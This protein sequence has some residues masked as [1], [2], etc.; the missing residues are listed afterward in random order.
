MRVSSSLMKFAACGF[1]VDLSDLVVRF[2]VD[3]SRWTGRVR[4][5][6]GSATI[7]AGWRGA[8]GAA[9]GLLVGVEGEDERAC[10]DVDAV[11]AELSEEIARRLGDPCSR[12]E[13]TSID[14][15]AAWYEDGAEKVR[16][17]A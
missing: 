10:E 9:D 1:V 4:L 17:T 3:A 15:I 11:A 12:E 6:I 16:R 7:T 2:G 8:E 5:E 14:R 13:R